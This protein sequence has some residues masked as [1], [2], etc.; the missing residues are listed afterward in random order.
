MDTVA[1]IKHSF[2]QP[3]SRSK[4]QAIAA[5]YQLLTPSEGQELAQFAFEQFDAGHTDQAE[6]IWL[7]LACLTPGALHNCSHQFIQRDI[8]YPGMLFRIA[9][10]KTTQE[11]LALLSKVDVSGDTLRLNRLL[12]ALAWIGDD[13]VQ[14]VFG[15]WRDRAP[16]WASTLYVP[17]ERYAHVAGWML[18][19]SGH[20]Q[21]LF[22]QECYPFLPF[23]DKRETANDAV[24]VVLPT[25]DHCPWCHLPVT[26]LFDCDL[27]NAHLDFLQIVGTG[28]RIITCEHCTCYGPI[29]SDI[30][31]NGTATWSPHNQK[32]SYLPDD[33][34][35]WIAL[36][37][38]PLVMSDMKR[39][40]FTVASEF[41][42]VSTT[43]FGGHPTWIQDADYPLCPRC[44]APMHF[45]AQFGG[46]DVEEFGEGMYYAFVCR[47]C[48]TACTTYQ[49]S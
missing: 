22:Y 15:T 39:H 10:Q 45:I 20:R 23:R 36:P 30:D 1:H 46:D 38:Q 29:Y 19:P 5:Q 12:I 21:D 33:A 47:A 44:T 13:D 49:Q 40:P 34:S 6:T 42:S 25:D 43:Q 3:W 9:D 35:E 18:T 48:Q 27:T 31:W 37:S 2:D 14:H 8:L 17:P 26:T 41:I 4:A 28:L 16:A 24:R 11:L 7:N 32:P